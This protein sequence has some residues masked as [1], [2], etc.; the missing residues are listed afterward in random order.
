MLDI[1]TVGIETTTKEVVNKEVNVGTIISGM[2]T[3][4][5]ITDENK[6][7][8]GSYDVKDFEGNVI[9]IS[10]GD[11]TSERGVMYSYIKEIADRLKDKKKNGAASVMVGAGFSKNYREMPEG[12]FVRIVSEAMETWMFIER[13]PSREIM[14]YP[15]VGKIQGH[16]PKDYMGGQ[17]DEQQM[18]GK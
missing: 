9:N 15:A 13:K 1:N 12:E 17:T 16:Y 4:K 8:Y 7:N 11:I 6:F 5:E 18:A 3:L 2:E 10:Y 14:I